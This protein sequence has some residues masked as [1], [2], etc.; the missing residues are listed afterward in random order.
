[1][2]KK[3]LMKDFFENG[4][5]YFLDFFI[6]HRERD[7]HSH[8]FWEISYV[9]EGRGTH[10]FADGTAEAIKEGEFIFISP[11]T[12]HCITSPAAEK[13]SWVHVCNFLV[14]PEFM[15][16]LTKHMT[17]ARELDEYALNHMLLNQKPFCIHLR[18]DSGSVYN[19]LMTAAHEYK[20]FS[21]CSNTIIE[22]SAIS[23]LI[24]IIRLYEKT[25]KNESVTTTRN[26]VIDDL[27]KYISSNFSSNLSLDYLAEYAH[28]SPAYLSRY[29]KQRTGKNLSD[30][31]AETRIE[32]AKYRLRT[33]NWTVN[34]ICEYC[35]YKSISNF[36]KAFKKAAGMT[37]SEYRESIINRKAY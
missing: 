24:Y 6:E 14:S 13:G 20:H 32:K 28:L 1:M 7:M 15:N 4:K 2:G 31:I 29:F 30:F 35:G 23:L 22:N 37:A 19:L 3:L 9:F 18:D 27:I 36:H 26:E 10:Y 11:G 25:I 17:A 34:D 33:S 8:E 16:Y 5:P 12:S 21:D